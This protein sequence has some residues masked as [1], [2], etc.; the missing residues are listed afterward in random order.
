MIH[1]PIVGCTQEGA[2]H[3]HLWVLDPLL[4]ITCMGWHLRAGKIEYGRT[5]CNV[6][7]RKPDVLA[8]AEVRCWT[9]LAKTLSTAAQSRRRAHER[10]LSQD[11]TPAPLR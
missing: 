11:G 6:M 9:N 5:V 3:L 10:T 4:G 7:S 8:K 1:G 2:P